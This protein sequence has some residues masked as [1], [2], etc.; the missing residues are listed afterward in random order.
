MASAAILMLLPAGAWAGGLNPFGK[1]KASAQPSPIDQYIR[2]A[3][4]RSYEAHAAVPSPG[5]LFSPAGRFSD[6]MRDPRASQIDDIITILIADTASAVSSGTTNTSRK[7]STKNSVAA[8]AGLTKATGPLANLANISGATQ[9]QG[10]GTTS[11]QTTLTTNLS[12]RVTHVLPNGNLVVEGVKQI[13]VNSEHQ[14]VSVRGVIRPVDLNPDNTIASNRL[15]DLEV[16]VNG[17]G[18]VG[19]AIRRPFILYRILMG[20]LPF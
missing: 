1:K 20:L 11:R 7:S 18:V 19:D 6:L 14:T 16:Q 13:S 2:D 5:S 9:L 8:L 12:T 17:K 10:Q 3:E 4:G 15:A